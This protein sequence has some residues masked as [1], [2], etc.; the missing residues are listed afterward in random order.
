MAKESNVESAGAPVQTSGLRSYSNTQLFFLTRLSWLV[1]QRRETAN[2]LD[3]TH[4][5]SK[6]LNKALYST[7]LDCVEEGVG[8]EAK[9]LLAQNQ[10]SN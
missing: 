5:Q 8:D 9:R 1:K 4:W 2:T 6:L 7:Y 10:S 3:S